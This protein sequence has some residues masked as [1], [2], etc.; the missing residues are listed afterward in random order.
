MAVLRR[1]PSGRRT[2][3]YLIGHLFTIFGPATF[4]GHYG[5][6]F[7]DRRERSTVAQDRILDSRPS[8]ILHEKNNRL[9]IVRSNR[10][11]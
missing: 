9:Q 8:V 5:Q 2:P 3:V 10:P 11:L 7:Q 1:R 6:V 4:S